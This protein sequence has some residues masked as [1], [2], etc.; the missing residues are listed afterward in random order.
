MGS[1]KKE[2]TPIRY[3]MAAIKVLKVKMGPNKNCF[4]IHWH[5]RVEFIRIKKGEMH[6]GYGN[7]VMKVCEGQMMMFLPKMP[8]K[9][10]TLA[11][12]VEYDVLM[13]DVRSFYNNAEICK[14]YLPAIFD[15]RARFKNIICD[16]ETVDCF[17]EIFRQAK[18][19]SL[20]I[21]ADIYRLF[22]CLFK[23]NLLELRKEIS[24]DETIMEIMKY[25]ETHLDENLTTPS[26][27]EY[28]G[29]SSE[30]FCRKFKGATGLT[31]MNYLKIYR[32]EEAY[33]M[34]KNEGLNVKETAASCGFDD[35]NYFARCFKAHFGMSPT[36][37]LHHTV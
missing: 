5:D 19:A 37:Y 11:S 15:G 36:K 28:F 26:L 16:R 33:K 14:A 20:G 12:D 31:P 3:N 24:R 9:G 21:I 8:H 23:N 35:A 4:P 29:Y 27:A 13:F 32:M 7:N 18:D 17:D 1:Y 34:M 6:A 22:N 25:M 10:Y 30:H 2:L